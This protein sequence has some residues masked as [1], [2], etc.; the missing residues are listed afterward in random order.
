MIRASVCLLTLWST[1][2]A[3]Q[4][5]PLVGAWKIIFPAGAQVQDGMRTVITATGTLTIS[6][7]GD[8]LVADLVTDPSPDFPKPRPPARF[9]AKSIPGDVV[10]LSNRK[11]TINMNGVEH[12]ANVVNVWILG[13]KGDSLVGTLEHKIEGEPSNEPEPVTG[14][15]QKS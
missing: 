6:A 15:R 13:A 2:L 3:A 5:Q 10:F 12:E 9:A 1:A 8:S 14:V 11:A 4:Q 7:V